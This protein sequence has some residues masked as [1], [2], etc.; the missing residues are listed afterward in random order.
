MIV[1]AQT[2]VRASSSVRE[3]GAG[4]LAQNHANAKPDARCRRG[5][6]HARNH[7]NEGVA[8]REVRALRLATIHDTQ[9]P[10]TGRSA[11]TP[12]ASRLVPA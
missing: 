6:G 9:P 4:A 11:A 1:A 7:A 2:C 8:M 3:L 5:G 10:H 12:R